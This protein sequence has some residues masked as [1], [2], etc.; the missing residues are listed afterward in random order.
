[1]RRCTWWTT[2]SSSTCR[3]L[4]ERATFSA[5]GAVSRQRC[6]TKGKATPTPKLSRRSSRGPRR[7]CWDSSGR[8]W[9]PCQ[10]TIPRSLISTPTRALPTR[11]L[12]PAHWTGCRNPRTN[13][14]ARLGSS[15]LTTKPSARKPRSSMSSHAREKSSS[16]K[17]RVAGALEGNEAPSRSGMATGAFSASLLADR[18]ASA[19]ASATAPPRL[20]WPA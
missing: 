6:F 8:S 12:S 20:G 17:H 14:L 3:L 10:K 19:A 15:F 7:E 9:P 5:Q 13:C 16:P 18:E 4:S 11:C 2:T 1:M